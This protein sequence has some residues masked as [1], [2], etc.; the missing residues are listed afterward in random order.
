MSRL[1]SPYSCILRLQMNPVIASRELKH[2]IE[3]VKIEILSGQWCHGDDDGGCGGGGG[4]GGGGG[5][6]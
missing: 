4:G 2:T 5:S 6:G 1:A 3:T